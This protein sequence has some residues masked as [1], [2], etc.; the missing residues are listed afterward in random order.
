MKTG[1]KYEQTLPK[2]VRLHDL[3]LFVMKESWNGSVQVIR[4][5]EN[6]ECRLN[7]LRE[8]IEWR[9]FPLPFLLLPL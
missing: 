6:S 3:E 7:S 9:A 8:L 1:A 2:S 4:Y 5:L